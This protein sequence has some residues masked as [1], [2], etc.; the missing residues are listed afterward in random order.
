[1]CLWE[2]FFHQTTFVFWSPYIKSLQLKLLHL[3][4]LFQSCTDWIGSSPEFWLT[5]CPVNTRRGCC[6]NAKNFWFI[7]QPWMTDILLESRKGRPNTVPGSL[8]HACCWLTAVKSKVSVLLCNCSLQQFA[9]STVCQQR[10]HEHG[11]WDPLST[12]GA[13]HWS[14]T[15]Q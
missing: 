15:P 14:Q 7:E 11:N 13:L 10:N 3:G 6:V 12:L 1:M 4:N 8:F 5:S 2:N 9:F